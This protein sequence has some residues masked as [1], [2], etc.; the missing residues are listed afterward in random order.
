ME[1]PPTHKWGTPNIINM[2]GVLFLYF[3]GKYF[4]KLA[5]D[6]NQNKWLYAI[7]SIVIF[8]VGSFFGGIVLGIIFLL[9]DF[10]Y[11]WDNDKANS[12]I[13]I[14]FGFLADYLFYIILKKKW[15]SKIEIQDEIQD[16]GKKSE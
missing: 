14:P 10:D 11:D 15:Q 13:A 6:N 5:E 3:I 8:Y 7:L 16:I 1:S 2:F 12:I 9:F 4:F